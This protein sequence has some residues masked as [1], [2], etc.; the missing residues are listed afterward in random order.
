MSKKTVVLD[1][2]GCEYLDELHIRIKEALEF[3]DYYG[4]NLDAFWDCINCDSDVDFV[5]IIGCEL[6][7]ND[8]K[9]TVRKILG[10][11]EKNKRYWADKGCP[12]DYKVIS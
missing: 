8:L 10:L 12:F 5:T 4:N 1:L 11:L 7:A 2:T 3:P 9:P 6:I